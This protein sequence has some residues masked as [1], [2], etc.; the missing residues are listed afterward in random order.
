M[1]LGGRLLLC[2]L[3]VL[4]AEKPTPYLGFQRNHRNFQIGKGRIRDF[5][6]RHWTP[7]E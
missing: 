4:S 3:F 6:V 5:E 2:G 7:G 1:S